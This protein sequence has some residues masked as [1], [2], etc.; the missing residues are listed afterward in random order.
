MNW[1]FNVP[2]IV[3]EVSWSVPLI[4]TDLLMLENQIPF[5]ILQSI[6]N[7]HMSR[8][9]NPSSS[10][11]QNNPNI[12]NNHTECTIHSLVDLIVKFVVSGEETLLIESSEIFH[13]LHLFYCCYIP[14][15]D[16]LTPTSR[17]IC[18]PLEILQVRR[19]KSYINSL[20][21]RPIF[22]N[23]NRRA[24]MRAPRM[25]PCATELQEAG[26][27]F[28]KARTASLFDVSFTN[29]VLH[30]PYFPLEEVTRPR[31]MN[32]I[33]FE[34]TSCLE[35]TP[36]TSYAVFM[37]CIINTSRDVIILQ[38]K[39]IIENKLSDEAEA[40]LFFNQL[41]Y[42]S[43]LDYETHYLVGLFKDVKKYCDS[44]WQKYRARL[45]RD[46]FS[47]P[48]SIISFIGAIIL[49]VL[50]VVQSFFTVLSFYEIS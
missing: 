7:L 28:K 3:C 47:N 34:Q 4:K 30:M 42:C 33:A 9:G 14:S 10:S 48:W 16:Q 45:F 40:A 50:T 19:I 17:N 49:L 13:L 15:R 43:Y 24:H 6:Y 18:F 22:R 12:Q 46:Y 29:G 8:S 44:K 20:S 23:L 38:R 32:L 36:L 11:T 27:T 37:D 39:G 5:F 25:I 31:I 21:N 35:E 2:D 41:R 1:N 26:I